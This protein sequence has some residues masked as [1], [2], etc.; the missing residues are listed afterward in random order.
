[1]A[2]IWRQA[3]VWPEAHDEDD[4]AYGADYDDTPYWADAWDDEDDEDEPHHKCS[5]AAPELNSSNPTGG[6]FVDYDPASRTGPPGSGVT[7]LDK[8][9]GVHPDEPI[10][11]YRGAPRHQESIVP[12]DFVTTDPQLAHDYAGTGRVLQ[13]Q[14][15][16]GDVVT[17]PDEWEGGEHIYRPRTAAASPTAADRPPQTWRAPMFLTD[18]RSDPAG[19]THTDTWLR[20]EDAYDE[21]GWRKRYEGHPPDPTPEGVR[22]YHATYV[23]LPDG[24]VLAAGKGKPPWL[25]HP[26][27]GGLDNRA[28]W[29]WV[30][31]DITHS[32]DWLHYMVRD[33]GQGYLYEVQ[34]HAGPFPWNGSA[35]EGWVTDY[36]VIV[37][38]VQSAGQGAA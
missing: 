10:T 37:K 5:A 22:W 29:T 28:H 25:D 26:Y 8:V 17:D 16:H 31:Y 1:V 19:R 27:H 14:V 6:V 15:G 9:K 32:D 2:R 21:W 11:I 18:E 24:E 35:K 38:K 34:P 4:D 13:K 30:E 36:A 7:T 20:P 3:E 12:G 33:H 23:D